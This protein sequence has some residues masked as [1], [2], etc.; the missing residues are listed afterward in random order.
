MKNNKYNIF[1]FYK[2]RN[3]KIFDFNKN[4]INLLFYHNINKF[5]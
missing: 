1:M 3:Q 5:V 2:K 4:N